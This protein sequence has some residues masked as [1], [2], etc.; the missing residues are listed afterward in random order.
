MPSIE[1]VVN[2]SLVE[3]IIQALTTDSTVDERAKGIGHIL[4]YIRK[5][6]EGFPVN[7]NDHFDWIENVMQSGNINRNNPYD[8][9]GATLSYRTHTMDGYSSTVCIY[10]K[11]N[12]TSVNVLSTF[13]GSQF[14]SLSLEITL[15]SIEYNF[16]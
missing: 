11:P 16:E 12:I 1:A 5:N 6:G 10:E 14:S 13:N 15:N 4:E 8:I 2:K 7:L 3:Y 9:T